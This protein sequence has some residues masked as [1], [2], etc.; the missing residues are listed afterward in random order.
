MDGDTPHLLAT[1]QPHVSPA[2]ARIFRLVD[3]VTPGCANQVSSVWLS[4]GDPDNVWIRLRHGNTANCRASFFFKHWIPGDPT[5]HGF[6]GATS[7]CTDVDDV[8][9]T[10]DYGNV[11]NT[12]ASDRRAD[13][14]PLQVREVQGI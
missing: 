5:V 2:L 7:S 14:A 11:R 4:R 13:I 12:T 1:T 8:R 9:I 6:K 10:L 3:T